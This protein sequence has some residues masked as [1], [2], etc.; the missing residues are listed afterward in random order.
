MWRALPV[1]TFDPNGGSVE[2]VTKITGTDGKLA[3]L[4]TPT[5]SGH[6]FL[7]WY[8]A[9][10]G[11]DRVTGEH[12]FNA[13]TTLYAHW[14]DEY[15]ITFDPNGGSVEPATM[16][17][18]TDG[19][20]SELPTAVRFGHTFE[21][22][23]TDAAGGDRVTDQYVFESDA[24]VYA[25]WSEGYAVTF[26]ASPGTCSPAEA[27]T[28]TDGKIVEL[29]TAIRSGYTFKGW[30]TDPDGGDPVTEATALSGA[31][32]L[33]A[34]WSVSSADDDDGP[35]PVTPGGS[36]GSSGKAADKGASSVTVLIVACVAA[37]M[38]VLMAHTYC[39]KR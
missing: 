15:T 38:A 13:S 1:I 18:G 20:L 12:V 3:T 7:G 19:K 11:G 32:K 6:T 29:P 16:I 24:T 27:R 17:T 31:V 5:C 26:D 21:G 9:Q 25:R 33:Y 34:H 36:G 35:C 2:T 8:T 37:V 30:Y 23:Y 22:W 28:G 39:S 4:P 14:T 10:T